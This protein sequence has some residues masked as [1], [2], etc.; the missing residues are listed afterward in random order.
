M[1]DSILVVVLVLS[2][3]TIYGTYVSYYTVIR[4]R[5]IYIYIY[6]YIQYTRICSSILHA[7][8]LLLPFPMRSAK[9]LSPSL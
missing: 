4:V 5:I 1:S 8:Q 9:C 7:A 3:R 2:T 6:E